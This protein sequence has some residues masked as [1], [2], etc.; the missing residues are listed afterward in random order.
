MYSEPDLAKD[1]VLQDS[2]KMPEGTPVVKGY[3]WNNGI[4]YDELLKT[5]KN[6][7]FQVR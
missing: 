7:G 4:N 6:S 3:D 5:F 2:A 1:A